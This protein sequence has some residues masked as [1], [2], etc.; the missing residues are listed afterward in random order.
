METSHSILPD[1]VDALRAIIA[2]R[3]INWLKRLESFNPVTR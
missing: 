1:D 3:Q 2:A